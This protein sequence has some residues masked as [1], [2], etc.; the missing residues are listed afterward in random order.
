VNDL[1]TLFAMVSAT[2]PAGAWPS[3]A[4]CQTLAAMVIATHPKVVLE[5]GTWTGDS[6]IPM[7]L[8]LKY[9]DAAATAAG[10]PSRG[11]MFVI[12]PW[13]AAASVEGQGEADATWWGKVDHDQAHKKF[14]ERL[15][16][17]E[18]EHL[19]GVIRKRSDDVDPTMF[20]ELD[21]AHIDGNH[22]EQAVR[23]VAR[24]APQVRV[25][26][27]LIADDLEWAGGHVRR[28]HALALTL[29]FVELYALGTGCVLQR[30]RA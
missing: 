19:V 11:R 24:F 10:Q 16:A 26:G 3:L 23:D 1:S 29:G 15:R 21:I 12:D 27:F 6:A 13:E 22:A 9:L 5:I 2:R 18:L 14:V 28:A 8:A 30:V 20:G 7:A 4:K 17:H 25:G